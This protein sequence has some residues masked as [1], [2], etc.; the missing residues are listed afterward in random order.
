MLDLKLTVMDIQ[1]KISKLARRLR[2][3]V[4][5]GGEV[6]ATVPRWVSLEQARQFVAQKSVWLAKAVAKM[7]KVKPRLARGTRAEYKKFKKQTEQFVRTRVRELNEQYGFKYNRI[8]IRNQKTRW[9]SASQK[10]NLSFNYKIIFLPPLLQDYLIVHE[11]CH[12]QEM[13]HSKRFWALVAQTIP[14]FK[15]ARKELK[16]V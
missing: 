6:V 9:G 3:T 11:L 1:F 2:I 13:N 14:S 15:K 8:F 5:P 7:Q 16:G 12:L 4:K 10:G